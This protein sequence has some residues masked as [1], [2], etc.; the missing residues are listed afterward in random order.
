MASTTWCRR[1]QRSSSLCRSHQARADAI[2]FYFK[3]PPGFKVDLPDLIGN[4]NPD[5]G[6]AR[7]HRNGA[8]RG[9]HFR[10]RDQRH[11]RDG[12]LQFPHERRKIRCAREVLRDDRVNYLTMD[13]KKT[14]GWWEMPSSKLRRGLEGD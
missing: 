14:G 6:V 12:K 8:G 10:P 5:W 2:V 4:Y 13:P 1:T 9:A 7:L 11:D 3:F